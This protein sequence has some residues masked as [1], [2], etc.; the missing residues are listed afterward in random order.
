MPSFHEREPFD[1][2]VDPPLI[3]PAGHKSASFLERVLRRGEFAVTAEMNPP[4]SADPRDVFKAAEPLWDVAD[5]I[6]ATDASGAN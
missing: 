5:A 4:D 3:P 6:N 1:P 2:T